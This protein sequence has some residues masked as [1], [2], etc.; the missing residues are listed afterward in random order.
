M[1]LLGD[2]SRRL[3]NRDDFEGFDLDDAVTVQDRHHCAVEAPR[4]PSFPRLM[5]TACAV[6]EA[7]C[8]ATE[9]GPVSVVLFSRDR[10]LSFE[11]DDGV[12]DLDEQERRAVVRDSIDV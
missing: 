1:S 7:A 4:D 8:D 9:E 10:H 3:S 6:T 5:D 12:R 2:L 11:V